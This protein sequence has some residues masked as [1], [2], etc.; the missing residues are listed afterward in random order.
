MFEP[1]L[2]KAHDQVRQPANGCFIAGTLIHTQEGLKPIE[3][4][5]VGD[6]VLSRPENPTQGSDA[7]YKR[8]TKAIQSE[9]RAIVRFWWAPDSMS[10]FADT[11]S[12]YVTPNHPVYLNPNGWVEMGRLHLPEKL[13]PGSIKRGTFDW[14]GKELVLASGASA[15]MLDVCDLYQTKLPTVAFH[16]EDDWGFGFLVDF[17]RGQPA[18]GDELHYE[19]EKLGE[20][21]AESRQRY[22][23]TV[24]DLEVEDWHTYFVGKMGLW[25]HDTHCLGHRPRVSEP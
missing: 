24:Y 5:Q 15:A 12:V 23:T 6:W 19:D 3:Q 9:N 17:A 20:A 10:L 21:Y 7:G 14:M 25:V 8:V 1:S 4:I 2:A 13:R 22:T 16:E 18:F 11:E